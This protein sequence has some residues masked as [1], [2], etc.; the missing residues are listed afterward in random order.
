M[1]GERWLPSRLHF[2]V[3]FWTYA[4][5]LFIGTHWPRL[6][7]NVPGVERPDLVIHFVIFAT[8]YL[9][10][11]GAAYFAGLGRWRSLLAAWIVAAA[12]AA[13]DEGLQAIPVIRRNAAWDDLAANVGGI[14]VGLLMAAGWTVV[15]RPVTREQ[16]AS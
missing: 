4:L 6:E 9:L 16:S 2:R 7:L 13:L 10:L 15:R 14:T 8:W 5:V 3:V 11:F 12:Y 1:P